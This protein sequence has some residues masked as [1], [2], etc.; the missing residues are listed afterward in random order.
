MRIIITEQSLYKIKERGLEEF[1]AQ[2]LLARVEI[3]IIQ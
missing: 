2:G 3:K 1:Q